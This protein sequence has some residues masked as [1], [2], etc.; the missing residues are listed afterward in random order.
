M[1]CEAL[2]G[3]CGAAF[4]VFSAP[5]HQM[6]VSAVRELSQPNV[7]TEQTMQAVRIKNKIDIPVLLLF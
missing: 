6:S 1:R 2:S 4:I 3:A 5:L 7:G